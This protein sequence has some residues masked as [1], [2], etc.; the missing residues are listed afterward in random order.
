MSDVPGKTAMRWMR[1]LLILLPVAAA[2]TAL[3]LPKLMREPEVIRT[4]DGVR[5]T[6]AGMIGDV[7]SKSV[8]FIG[9]GHDIPQHHRIELQVIRSLHERKRPIVVALEMFPQTEQRELDKW[10][11][12]ES[13]PP[14]FIKAYRRNWGEDWRLY[15]DIFLY[16]REHR[17]PMIGINVPQEVVRKVSLE[18]FSALG[19]KEKE[20]LPPGVTC[21]FGA[22]YMDYV[23]R[24]FRA[25]RLQGGDFAHFC[26]AQMLWNKGMA[27]NLEKYVGKNRRSTVIVLTGKAHAVKEGIPA[28]LER[29]TLPVAVLLPDCPQEQDRRMVVRDA[30]YLVLR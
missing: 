15:R 28:H 8:V 7:A 19:A 2:A 25:H 12:G 26:E 29:S 22:D 3:A 24:V 21:S 10:V 23:R 16:A 13:S 11:A 14:E 20:S 1:R 4:G 30:D 27:W 18:G 5:M 17:I 6:F 9:E